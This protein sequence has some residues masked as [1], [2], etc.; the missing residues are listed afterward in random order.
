[1][2]QR[3]EKYR[4]NRLKFLRHSEIS[5]LPHICRMKSQHNCLARGAGSE[6]GF[7]YR[8]VRA[9]ILNPNFA[10]KEWG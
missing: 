9:I 8:P 6:Q 5:I 10:V 7:C 1:V 2:D 3:F 4:R